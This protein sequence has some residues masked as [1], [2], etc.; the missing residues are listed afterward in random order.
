MAWR[1][2]DKENP[3]AAAPVAAQVPDIQPEPVPEQSY[4]RRRAGEVAQSLADEARSAIGVGANVVGGFFGSP[5]DL[6]EL[7]NE[8]LVRPGIEA[9]GGKSLP[10]E[11][12]Y[13]GQILPGSKRMSETL[14][15]EFAK[16]KGAGD[17]LQQNI[18]RESAGILSGRGI[19]RG[20]SAANELLRRAG[21]PTGALKFA[22]DV[23]K[24]TAANLAKEGITEA[25]GNETAGDLAHLGTMATLSLVD[26]P[27]VEHQIGMLYDRARKLLPQNAKVGTKNI[28][29]SL[30]KLRD[31]IGKTH[32]PSEG[33]QAALNEINKFLNAT[34][35]NEVPVE[36][37]EKTIRSFNDKMKE[38]LFQPGDRKVKKNNKRLLQSVIRPY[39]DAL[40][41]YG[42]SNPEWYKAYSE[43]NK[44]YGVSSRRSGSQI[45]LAK[46]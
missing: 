21:K 36:E 10:Y 3:K 37:V 44:S 14:T 17:R 15:P 27:K 32:S 23:G 12:T 13:L 42:A 38:I 8:L 29:D 31:D 9:A 28:R 18:A 34:Q 7:A 41:E 40:K 4:L 6:A 22:K 39:H 1:F 26:L 24:V 2:I 45:Y 20:G 25:T 35:G 11:Q 33:E 46:C 16:P 19:F 30:T 5:G 43:A